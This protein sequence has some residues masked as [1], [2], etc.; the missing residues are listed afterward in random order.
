MRGPSRTLLISLLLIAVAVCI[1]G[2]CYLISSVSNPKLSV[3]FIKRIDGNG[4]WRLQFGITNVGDRF[5]FPA[6]R[7]KIEGFSRTNFLSVG[8]KP[9][10]TG[11]AP[12]EGQIVETIL[13][14][15]QMQSIDRK[16][17]LTCLF[18]EDGLRSR[19][20]R[21]QW[22]TNGPGARVNWLIPKKFKGMAFNVKGT[23]DWF[24]PFNEQ[25]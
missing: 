1:V 5:V 11:L 4:H 23:S 17:R 12:G 25:P 19:I 9:P 21:W 3:I 18:A 22:G 20:Y 6:P 14:E 7:G 2:G 8:V 15:A 10:T 13:S 24:E 16:W